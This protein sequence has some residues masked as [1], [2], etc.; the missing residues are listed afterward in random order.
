MLGYL[1]A[2]FDW[3]AKVGSPLFE[4]I[5]GTVRRFKW[6][7]VAV[8]ASFLA[9]IKWLLQ[10]AK[11]LTAS[12]VTASADIVSLLSNLRIAEA[13]TLW[14]Q[15]GEGAALMNCVVPLDVTLSMFGVLL[16]LWL[17]IFGIKAALFVYRH[18][19]TIFG[20]GTNG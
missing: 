19:P 11:D 6:F 16:T 8:L 7:F 5:L 17:I 15:I 13:G 14:G 1:K 18:I 12:L 2:L 10:L 20:W 4:G 9:P 3:F